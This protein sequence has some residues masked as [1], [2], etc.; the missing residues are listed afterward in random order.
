MLNTGGTTQTHNDSCK[1]R[2]Q[3]YLKEKCVVFCFFLLFCFLGQYNQNW[4]LVFYPRIQWGHV[5]FC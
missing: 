1:D 2:S 3:F 5:G 4:E